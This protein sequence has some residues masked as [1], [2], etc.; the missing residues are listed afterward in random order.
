MSMI[1]LADLDIHRTE[2]DEI[3]PEGHVLV[4]ALDR[5]G[6]LRI[7]LY[8]GAEPSDENY[9]G[10]LI[11]PRGS[12][13]QDSSRIKAY[14]AEGAFVTSDGDNKAKLA[15]LAGQAGESTQSS[16][17]QSLT[18]RYFQRHI[19]SE[20][21]SFTRAARR[22]AEVASHVA[23]NP[24]SESSRIA[25]GEIVRLAAYVADLL[26]TASK[27]EATIEVMRATEGEASQKG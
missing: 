25:S 24:P 4:T 14:D 19:A 22:I 6:L 16:E 2:T 5:S 20:Q 18:A 8:E 12:Q 21:E 1:R 11:V 26:R 27:L 17:P 3:T 13:P 9:R 15:C 10:C 7:C 23:D